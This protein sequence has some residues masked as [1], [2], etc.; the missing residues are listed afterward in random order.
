MPVWFSNNIRPRST[1]P[2]SS[3]AWYRSAILGKP[4]AWGT[5]AVSLSIAGLLCVVALYYFRRLE[6]R[7]ADIV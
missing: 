5:L 1:E 7:F 3:T 2:P 4:F 6:A